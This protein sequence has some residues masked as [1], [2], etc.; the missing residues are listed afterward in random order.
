MPA[1]AAAAAPAPTSFLQ[2]LPE[3]LFGRILR[4]LAL[5]DD[6]TA[7]AR[8]L[9]RLG[10]ASKRLAARTC[11]D[12]LW[13]T[14]FLAVWPLP[15]TL[16]PNPR[17]F[18][19]P[20]PVR[21]PPATDD[22][23]DGGDGGTAAAIARVPWKQLFSYRHLLAAR[24]TS[25]PAVATI[26]P[27]GDSPH[28][29]EWM[30]P[31]VLVTLHK[32]RLK[33]WDRRSLAPLGRF[34]GRRAFKRLMQIDA[35]GGAVAAGTFDGTVLLW[36]DVTAAAG[37]SKRAEFPSTLHGHTPGKCVRKVRFS[38]PFIASCAADGVVIVWDRATGAPLRWLHSGAH[39]GFGLTCHGD[40]VVHG[41]VEGAMTMWN[42]RTGAIVRQFLGHEWS[43]THLWLD[44]ARVVSGSQDETV[45][46]W[47]AATG[48]CLRVLDGHDEHVRA[49]DVGDGKIATGDCAGV[50]RVWDLES[51]DLIFT[52]T[53]FQLPG[54]R[55]T[56]KDD[57][58]TFITEIFIDASGLV[59]G[60]HDNQLVKLDFGGDIP[61]ASE[62]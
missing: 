56:W 53:L 24:W 10:C 2:D 6:R 21:P 35:D 38:G 30:D 16:R 59:C 49:M 27:T 25:P 34:A 9:C 26:D 61:F 42:M 22:G 19:L 58:T 11:G 45:R 20:F 28:S 55:S 13:R 44:G 47:D 7:G 12:G 31:F 62:F 48:E 40:F 51:G 8:A 39:D 17:L 50:V 4:L 41:C 23:G 57:G 14:F 43:V 15:R 18:P 33:L 32:G 36:E 29:A 60:K 3:E 54:R 5:R 1:A 37:S 46:V 52:T